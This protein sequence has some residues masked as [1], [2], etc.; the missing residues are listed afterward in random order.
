MLVFVRGA[1][2]IPNLRVFSLTEVHMCLH[3]STR[4]LL[5]LGNLSVQCLGPLKLSDPLEGC[6]GHVLASIVVAVPVESSLGVQH[7]DSVVVW[8]AQSTTG[9]VRAYHR[10]SFCLHSLVANAARNR[11]P[12]LVHATHHHALAD[13]LFSWIVMVA[14]VVSHKETGAIF[15]PGLQ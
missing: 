7:V 3:R 14:T 2:H 9:R 10:S 13:R 6:V 1:H 5:L 8:R 11:G 4:C 15:H 12:K